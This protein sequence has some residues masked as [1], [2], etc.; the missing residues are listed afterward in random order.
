[1]L[2]VL[3]TVLFNQYANSAYA[4]DMGTIYIGENLSAVDNITITT[5]TDTY[6]NFYG[7]A[8]GIYT[9]A[10][11]DN[12]ETSVG[13]KLTITTHGE[14]SDGIRSNPSGFNNWA[15][16]KGII[17]VDDG[18]TINTYGMSADGINLNG[19]TQLFI[20][21]G[22]TMATH[23]TDPLVHS[24]G[25]QSEGAHAVRANFNS[26]IHIGDYLTA[27]TA[28]D[29]SHAVYSAQ[30]R[31]F[32]PAQNGAK[33]YI[34]SNL[35][36]ETLGNKS[37]AAYVA[38]RNG[39]IDIGD[40]A[41]LTTKGNESHAV[42]VN[43]ING[44]VLLGDNAALVTEGVNS[45]SAYTGGDTS[46]IEFTAGADIATSGNSSYAL[47]AER[48]S[49]TSNLNSGAAPVSGGKFTVSGDMVAVNGA[50]DL[51]MTE[52]SFFK[53]KT[54]AGSG[55]ISLATKSARW[56][57]T[58]D[59]N[60]TSLKLDDTIV[61]YST[62]SIGTFITTKT[63]SG[64]GGAFIMRVDDQPGGLIEGD[65]LYISG[66]AGSLTGQHYIYVANNGA[67]HSTGEEKVLL[68]ET[69]D[70]SCAANT[71]TLANITSTGKS[72]IVEL[73]AFQYE[74]ATM[75]ESYTYGEGNQ[76]HLYSTG[77]TTTTGS[78]GVNVFYA[79]YLLSYA[80]TQTLIQRL[81]DLR[82]T[83]LLSGFWFRA[84]GGKFESNASSFVHPFDMDY[85]GVQL[86][87]DRKYDIGWDGDF[88]A[89]VMFGYSKGDIDYLTS[90]NG[91]VDSKTLGVYGTFIA[92][93][94]FFADLVLKYQWM[95]NDFDVLDSAGDKVTGGGVSTGGYGASLE[96]GQR[97]HFKGNGRGNWYIEPQVQLSY[98]RQD[99]GYFNASNGLHIGV[100]PFTSVL[101]RGGILLG[102]ENER[103][104]FYAKVSKVKEFNGDVTIMANSQPLPD[105]FG[106]SWWVYGLG[107]TSRVNDRN[108]IYID[109]ERASGGSFTQVWVAKAGW[110]IEL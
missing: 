29:S 65:M 73:G 105:S 8:F 90:G 41:R 18:L 3:M 55:N 69:N 53:G 6:I 20:G 42:Y 30:G 5:Y 4:I 92:P 52:G 38:S 89:G 80:E 26:Q 106:G 1:M 70:T 39:V 19:S 101:G 108:N 9:N 15:G 66:G 37:Y 98:M 82:D 21:S 62:A 45:H 33:I 59:S 47:F 49:I 75:T 87:Y 109:I 40:N 51:I 88:H 102:Y 83:P 68:V 63:L 31:G 76:W 14:A 54:D 16:A 46:S 11:N 84:H 64:S 85:W 24:N 25:D 10:G 36:A 2:I 94:G 7:H 61:D 32:P 17:R 93:N 48:G 50:I 23:C 91:T 44:K 95:D 100:E 97:I 96:L 71:F 34:E 43:S 58:G 86:G 77:T 12:T 28:G 60:L 99:G 78:G 72:Q 22:S 56:D 57:V 110:R 104:N 74:L 81:G 67:A 13:K 103:T 79:G 27:T 35:T 107:F